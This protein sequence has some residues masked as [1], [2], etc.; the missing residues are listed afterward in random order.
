MLWEHEPQ[1][2]VFTAFSSS[3]KLPRVFVEKNTEYM[4]SISFRKQ[5]DEK[6]KTTC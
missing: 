1:A 5:R 2:N 4:F 3:L 6:R